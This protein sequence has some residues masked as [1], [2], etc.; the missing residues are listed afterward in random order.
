MIGLTHFFDNEFAGS[1]HGIEKGGLSDLGR[2]LVTR[3][4]AMGI[5]IDLAHLSP[6]AIDASSNSCSASWK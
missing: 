6:A 1:A 5:A 2:E 3:M 4:Q